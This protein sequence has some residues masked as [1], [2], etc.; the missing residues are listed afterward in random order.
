M[1]AS[2]T[3]VF[4]CVLGIGSLPWKQ[5]ISLDGKVHFEGNLLISEKVSTYMVSL[6][7][8]KVQ[9]FFFGKYVYLILVLMLYLPF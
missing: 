9:S 6:R 5:A 8:R 3:H 1:R 4:G 2:M 7:R